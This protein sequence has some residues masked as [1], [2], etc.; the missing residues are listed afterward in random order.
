MSEP[1]LD[2]L[3]G[4]RFHQVRMPKGRIRWN[5]LLDLPPGDYV[6]GEQ[7]H[8]DWVCRIKLTPK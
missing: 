2:R 5:P 3:D 8:P 7:N 4:N 1:H 6:L